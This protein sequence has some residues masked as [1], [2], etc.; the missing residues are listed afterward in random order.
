MKKSLVNKIDVKPKTQYYEWIENYLENQFDFVC[1]DN[2]SEFE[3]YAKMA[4]TKNG[5]IKF[6][7]GKHEK[8]DRPHISR[9]ENY[10][11]G[12]NNKEKIA[13]LKKELSSL[14]T[15]QTKNKKAILNKK[16]EIKNF[17]QVQR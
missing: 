16:T 8:D 11:L 2:L 4:L 12:W 9:K 3:R 5:L 7:K 6:R 14:Q 15:Q 1:V 13:A 10:F 17:R